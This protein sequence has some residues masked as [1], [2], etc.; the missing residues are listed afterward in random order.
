M[1]NA[2]QSTQAAPT[3]G[4]AGATG[5]AVGSIVG[6]G[7][8][9][10]AG[11]AF[12]AAGPSAL[13]AFALNGIIAILTALSLSE[14]V[15][16][17]PES[18]G[19]YTYSQK[20]LP[21]EVSFGVGWVAWLSAIVGAV[22][23]TLGFAHFAM[24]M[25]AGVW[26]GLA[27]SAPEWVTAG[28]VVKVLAVAT[29][30]VLS[31][32]LARSTPSGGGFANVG[33]VIAFGVLIV[34]GL[35]A[36]LRQPAAEIG[37][38]FRPFF[39]GGFKGLLLAMGYSFV[40]YQ[41]FGLLSTVSGDVRDPVKTV[42]R[43]MILSLL[44]AM[45]IYIPLL[46]VV[47]TAGRPDG[48]AIVD[49]ATAD[50][51][52]IVV[53]AA[54]N[55]LGAFG[56]WVV[57]VAALLSMYS[58]LQASLFGA[59]RVVFKM[60][61][62][63]TLPSMLGSVHSNHGTPSIAITATTAFVVVTLLSVP[64]IAVAGAASSL[65][66]LASYAVAHALSI[67]I[68]RRAVR[69]PPPFRTPL[70]PLI[71]VVGGLACFAL[72]VFQGVLVPSAGAIALLWLGAGFM[73]FL[74]LLAQRARVKGTF[75]AA[76]DPELVT[77]HGRA[78]LVLVPIANPHNTRAMIALADALV[79]EHAGR[80]VLQTVVDAPPDWQPDV[81]PAPIARTQVIVAELLK[82]SMQIRGRAET[83][84]TIA[85]QPMEEIVRVARL[86][87]C[88]SVLVGLSDVAA[89]GNTRMLEGLLN[90]LTADVVVLR[91]PPEWHPSDARRILVPI[92]GRGGHDHL[93]A[94]LL[95]SLSR[96][97]EREVTFMRVMPQATSNVE[98]D[99]VRHA[100]QR[101]ADDEVSGTSN[102]EVIRA[103]DLVAAVTDRA[104]DSDLVILGVQRLNR[105][106]KLFGE[107]IRQV[108]A[109][110]TRPMVVM[111]IGRK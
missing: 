66:S 8:L 83:L 12:A 63:R 79:P 80:V 51:E 27:G 90:K 28:W 30:V 44:I 57:I 104:A 60:A 94:T 7:I 43:A 107:F 15:S 5:I 34:V 71:P 68:R 111:S 59:S 24:V 102:V 84:I 85:P 75:S 110:T 46:F 6:G 19:T 96:T 4:L 25:V 73:L 37:D 55:Y 61:L 32:R 11:V 62:D 64:N 109:Q 31:A 45:V 40:V 1:S 14:M 58:A 98:M 56:Y 53:N 33:K 78:P 67:L 49:M 38:A 76:M 54:R 21:V 10:L 99:K 106:T 17:F 13:L 86:H 20:V 3:I 92:G 41:G 88:E 2:S 108:S 9:V 52:N 29:T 82:A 74:G 50:P 16:K 77:L 47:V 23:Y 89:G 65:V 105:R 35:A 81:D 91:A 72:A 101:I 97:M 103:D 100:L 22:L 39:A 18:G 70:F 87:R 42:P 48:V 95:G 93:R 26:A 69:N 36:T